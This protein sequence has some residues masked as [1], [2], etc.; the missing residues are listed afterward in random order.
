MQ[1][2]RVDVSGRALS[3][4]PDK[5]VRIGRS[6]DADVVLSSTSVSR[7][8]AELRPDPAGWKL[9]DVGSAGGTYVA[10][11]RVTEVPLSGATEIQFGPAGPGTTITVT[12]DDTSVAADAPRAQAPAPPPPPATSAGTAAPPAG[13]PQAPAAPVSPAAPPPPPAH[14]P[15]APP[16]PAHTDISEM[17][18]APGM[19]RPS[20]PGQ[21]PAPPTGPDLLLVAEGKEHRFRHPVTVTIG[22]AADNSVVLEDQGVSRQHARLVAKPGGWTFENA[23]QTGS[24]LKGKPLAREEIDEET[25]IRLG[26]PVAGEILKVIPI[27]AAEVEVARAAAK[28]RN[29][30]LL[31]GGIG[32]AAA[33]VVIGLVIAM[34]VVPG[35]DSVA[36]DTG[37]TKEELNRAQSATVWIT[38]AP[39]QDTIAM[40]SG[41]IVSKD[42]K[43]LTNAHVADPAKIPE[44]AAKGEVSPEYVNIHMTDPAEEYKVGEPDYVAKVVESDGEVDSAVVQIVAD[45]NGDRVDP[46]SLNLPT[47]SLGDSDAV[48][49]GD[50][51]ATIG[52]PMLPKSSFADKK[53]VLFQ[54]PTVAQGNV[55]TILSFEGEE[56]AVFDV[57]A[58]ISSGNSGGAAVNDDGELV[59]VPTSIGWDESNVVT[60]Q[61]IP[62]AQHVPILEAAGVRVPSGK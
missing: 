2:L 21:P 16:A 18:I 31:W 55:A 50:F 1:S 53:G 58:R 12:L 24:F 51:I 37:L 45:G 10:G 5:I 13:A 28:R 59:G 48:E 15:P 26:H 39:T 36:Q 33:V 44:Y 30:L 49:R 14:Q 7:A 4:P 35:G 22:R 6:I 57:T 20:A 43:I 3:F 46:A 47:I 29:K 32:A 40:G 17:T 60:G 23:S 34:F 38:Y 54:P 52:F 42:G 8:H 27:Y 25:E 56:R 11:D 41:S 62:L 19:A 61:V 9:V